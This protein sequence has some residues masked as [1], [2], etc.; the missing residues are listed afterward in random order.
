MGWLP[1]LRAEGRKDTSW[2]GK[3]EECCNQEGQRGQNGGG[4]ETGHF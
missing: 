4:R 3:E 2:E 1:S